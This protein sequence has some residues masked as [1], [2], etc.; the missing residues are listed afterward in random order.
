[1]RLYRHELESDAY[2]SLSPEGRALLVEFRALFNGRENRVFLSRTQMELRLGV[3][4]RKAEKARD[5][6]L[7]RGFIHLLVPGGF[8][9]KCPH[10]SEYALTNEP[11]NPTQDGAT[12]PKDYM[13]WRDPEKKIARYMVNKNAA[14]NAPRTE[15]LD[16]LKRTELVQGVPRSHDSS[17]PYAVPGVPTDTVTKGGLW[18]GAIRTTGKLQFACILSGLALAQTEAVSAA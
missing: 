11:I 18:W 7:D 12:P 15:F 14:R 8:N 5:E 1:M 6:L 4:R 9:R 16:P 3:G 17:A 10:A 13:R 2:R